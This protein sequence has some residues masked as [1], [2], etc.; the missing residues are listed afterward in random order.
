METSAQPSG[1]VARWISG[2]ENI[3]R[4]RSRSNVVCTYK[5]CNSIQIAKLLCDYLLHMTKE[6]EKGNSFLN[7]II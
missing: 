2:L 6:K 3:V 1:Q 7:I 5:L 4:Q